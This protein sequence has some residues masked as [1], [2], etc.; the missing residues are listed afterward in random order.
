MNTVTLDQAIRS[1]AGEAPGT[2]KQYLL[3][4]KH[5][6]SQIKQSLSAFNQNSSGKV[7]LG[8]PFFL[9]LSVFGMTRNYGILSV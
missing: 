9:F 3:D 2:T 7:F 8:Y 1:A 5:G 4:Q 6:I